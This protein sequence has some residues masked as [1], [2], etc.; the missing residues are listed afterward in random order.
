[1]ARSSIKS[2]NKPYSKS[3]GKGRGW[4]EK[5]IYLSSIKRRVAPRHRKAALKGSGST[6]RHGSVTSAQV[7]RKMDRRSKRS[8][9]IDRS[10]QAKRVGDIRSKK[11]REDWRRNPNQM[12]LQG[13]DTKI[14]RDQYKARVSKKQLK[15]K[16]QVKRKITKQIAKK[17]QIRD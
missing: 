5:A 7:H 10:K 2:Y 11:D 13:I 3:R 1:M 4:H 14:A 9:L 6:G 16:R 12:D 17:K 8:Q 15:Q